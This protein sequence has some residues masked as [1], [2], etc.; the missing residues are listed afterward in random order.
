MPSTPLTPE[1]QAEV[2]DLARAIREAIDTE[3]N[4][5]AANLAL[6]DDAHVFGENEFRILRP[7]PQD[8]RQGH[9]AAAGAKKNGYEGA[10]VTC[11]HCGQAAEFH[12]HRARTPLSLVG[13]VG[14]ECAYY[15]CRRCGQ[16]TFP[17]DETAGLTARKQT[18]ALE[19][20]T[21]LAGAVADGFEKGA[22]LLEEMAG[23]RLGESTVERTTEGAGQRLEEIVQAGVGRAPRR[24]GPGTRTTTADGAPTSR[25]TPPASGSKGKGAAPPRGGW[26]TWA[27]SATP[28]PIGRGPTRSRCRCRPVTSRGC[29]PWKTSARCSARPAGRVGMDRADR[30]IGLSDGGSGLEDR[31]RENFPRV[32]V[33]ILDFFHPAEKLTGLARLLHPQDEERAEEQA[34]GWCQLL[35]AEG[36]AV[37]AAVLREWDWPRR[38]GLSEAA[39][40]LIGYL[41]RQRIGWNTPNTWRMAGASAAGRWRAPARRWWGSD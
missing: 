9:R 25:S 10:S 38:A 41:E 20:V 8:R 17:F 14:Y 19:R 12:S 30:W 3:L 29:T 28:V 37:L 1:K 26:P 34:R 36:G 40:E 27:W 16:G 33:I 6:A 31:L 22:D 7:G 24:I 15:L 18:P 4:E 2:D 11:P 39:D 5:L 13:P 32:E 23:V 35:K 21:A